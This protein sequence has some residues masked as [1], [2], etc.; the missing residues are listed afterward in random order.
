MPIKD[1]RY[2]MMSIDAPHYDIDKDINMY[3]FTKD[4]PNCHI[5]IYNDRNDSCVAFHT[6]ID[7]LKGLA[8]FIY[9]VVGEK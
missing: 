6:S 7:K 9:K 5:S 2:Y 4:R 8:D 1:N 3:I